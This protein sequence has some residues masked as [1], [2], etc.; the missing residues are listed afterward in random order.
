MVVSLADRTKSALALGVGY[1]TTEGV[2]A[3]TTYSIFNVLHRAD[4]LQFFAKAQEIDTRIGVAESLPHF[5]SPGQTLKV[6]PDIFRDVI[7]E[8]LHRP[9]R[10]A[11]R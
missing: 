2:L 10:R 5:W 6:G 11:G 4:T 3:D 1:S 7:R 9:G 8:R